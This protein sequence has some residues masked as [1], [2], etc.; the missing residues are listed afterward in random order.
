MAEKLEV[1]P[2]PL[3]EKSY[4]LMLSRALVAAKPQ[5]ATRIWKAVEDARNS[6]RYKKML[7]DA[8]IAQRAER[9]RSP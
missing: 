1:L 9:G 3:I 5:L 2:L 4:Y 7:R 8:E 6:A